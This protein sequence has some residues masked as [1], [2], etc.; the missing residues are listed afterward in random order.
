MNSIN[1]AVRDFAVNTLGCGCPEEVFSSIET[2]KT[3]GPIGG[4]QPSFE[5]RI[6]G[7]LMIIG[8]AGENI[9]SP[10]DSLAT[11]VAGGIRI[12]DGEKFNRLRIVVVSDDPEC[13]ET[14]R[15]GFARIPGLD[16]RVHL[17]VVKKKVIDGMLSGGD[18]VSKGKERVGGFITEPTVWHEMDGPFIG[19]REHYQEKSYG[20]DSTREAD[21]AEES[22]VKTSPADLD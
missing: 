1:K 20:F 2:N 8:V 12:R 17:H 10:E 19:G 11:L 3:P 14:L 6:G 18:S 22:P 15:P 16:D 13:E 5:I 9:R 21:A 4:I 7:R